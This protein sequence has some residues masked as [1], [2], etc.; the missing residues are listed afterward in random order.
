M[1]VGQTLGAFTAKTT[2]EDLQ[3]LSEL[4]EA[5]KVTPVV[6]R[7]YDLVETADA[8]RYLHEGHPAGKIVVTV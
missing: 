4:I 3:A 7:T 6:D 5:G 8:V 1:F 2:K